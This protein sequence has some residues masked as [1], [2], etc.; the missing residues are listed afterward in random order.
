MST[1]TVETHADPV[2]DVGMEVA[3]GQHRTE[4]RHAL[5][6]LTVTVD[7][8]VMAVCVCS[9]VGYGSNP[10]AAKACLAEHL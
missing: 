10:E 7:G 2:T 1:M 6:S 8:E 9:A 3:Y 5:L 4:T